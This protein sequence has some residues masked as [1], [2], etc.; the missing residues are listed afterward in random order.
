VN[1]SIKNR[2]KR[3]A[4]QQQATAILIIELHPFQK[5]TTNNPKETINQPDDHVRGA[6][7]SPVSCVRNNNRFQDNEELTT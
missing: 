1:L 4:I 3:H 7:M 2:S 6:K 5:S